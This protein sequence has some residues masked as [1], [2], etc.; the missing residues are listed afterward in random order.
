MLNE[1]P[2]LVKEVVQRRAE[3]THSTQQ[4]LSVFVGTWN[5]NGGK[6]MYN[7][8][9]RHEQSLVSWLYPQVLHSPYDLVAVGLEEIVDLN[10]SNIMKAG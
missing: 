6:N 4:P 10:A 7:V 2:E 8:A 9:F 3:F 1:D 5:V